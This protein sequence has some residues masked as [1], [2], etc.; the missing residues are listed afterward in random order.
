MAD[1]SN[2]ASFFFQMRVFMQVGELKLCRWI[3]K[4]HDFLKY[5]L[6]RKFNGNFVSL[7]EKRTLFHI[8][9]TS[10]KKSKFKTVR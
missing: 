7:K 3:Y 6:Y 1:T 8:F 5:P 9:L 2:Q 4:V 10:G